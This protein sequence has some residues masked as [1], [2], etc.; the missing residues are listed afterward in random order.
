MLLWKSVHNIFIVRPSPLNTT[1]PR[2]RRYTLLVLGG[3]WLLAHLCCWLFPQVFEVWNAQ[4]LDQLFVL[5]DAVES[6][7]PAY[8]D[9]LVH[10]DLDDSSRQQLDH[11]YLNRTQYAQVV[12]NLTAMQVAVQM[13]D[14]IFAEPS[15]MADD[16]ALIDA[17]AAAGFI[18]Y[19]LAL[20]L[21][22][23]DQTSHALSTSA[24]SL[25]YLQQ[26]SW[27]AVVPGDIREFYRGTKPLLT[28]PKLAST[29][30]GLGYLSVKP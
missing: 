27:Q 16:Q 18:Y 11:F 5:R 20:T 13:H 17:T 10:V 28:F 6:L 30:R 3:A 26:T 22:H 14:V 29:S 8:D 23:R 12:H 4:T 1:N 25:S 21:E 19:G 2:L 24:A 9:T 7:R 15:N